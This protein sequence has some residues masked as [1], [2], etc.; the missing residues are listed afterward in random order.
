MS[1]RKF[2]KN[3]DE[4]DYRIIKELQKD[5]R[6]SSSA[7]A[8]VLNVNERTVRKRVDSLIESGIGRLTFVIEPQAFGYGIAVDI[9]LS[10]DSENEE[11]IMKKLLEIS[12][13]SY[14][15]YGQ[16]TNDLSLEAFFKTSEEMYQ[17]LRRTLPSIQGVKVKEFTLVPKII[18]NIDEWLPSGQD[19]GIQEKD[20]SKI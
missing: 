3:F 14:L 18:R 7:I 16:G 5:A 17:F 1:K 19:F 4:L 9:F 20:T 8:R 11:V 6:V 10:I 15:A 12:Q 2:F 13:I